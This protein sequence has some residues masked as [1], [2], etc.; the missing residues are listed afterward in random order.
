MYRGLSIIV[1]APVLDEEVKIGD[2]V[3]RAPRGVVD[4]VIVVDDGSTDSTPSVAA[5]YADGRY[6]RQDNAGPSAARNRGIL[7]SRGEFIALLD[8]KYRILTWTAL[9]IIANLAKVDGEQ[10]I[11]AIFNKYYSYL[12]NDYLVTVATVVGHSVKIALAKPYLTQKIT[13]ELLKVDVIPVTPHLTEECKRVIMEKT[14]DCF[15]AVFDQLQDK[16]EVL[17]LVKRQLDSPRTSLRTKARS[18]LKKRSP[19]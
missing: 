15:D 19:Y 10:K 4:E 13:A 1:I 17:S 7:E 16:A 18:F 3:R 2:V 8:S 6:V 5:R 12:Y 14:I 9:T 11:D